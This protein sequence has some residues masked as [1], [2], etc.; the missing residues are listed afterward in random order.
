MKTERAT[1]PIYLCA[2]ASMAG[3]L[4]ARGAENTNIGPEMTWSVFSILWIV[5]FGIPLLF[6][7][8]YPRYVLGTALDGQRQKPVLLNGLGVA[9]A[10]AI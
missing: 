2:G 10:V 3:F 9:S 4:L 7:F 1:S 5:F 6:A 8:S